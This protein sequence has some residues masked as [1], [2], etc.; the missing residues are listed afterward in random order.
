MDFIKNRK[1]LKRLSSLFII[2]LFLIFV[3]VILG[4]LVSNNVQVIDP[5]GNVKFITKDFHPS[6]SSKTQQLYSTPSFKKIIGKSNFKDN[7]IVIKDGKACFK[8]GID[9]PNES[10]RASHDVNNETENI[11]DIQACQCR[12]E[13]HGKACSEPE[14]IW[15]AFMVSRQP[16]NA[17]LTRHPHNIFYIINGVTSI[18]METLE[19]QILELLG[20]V[21]LFVLCD[22]VQT[23]DA[24]LLMQHQMNKDF[25]SRHKDYVLLLKDDTCSGS[26]IYRRMKRIIGSQMRPLDVLINGHSDEILNRKAVNYL[27]WHNNW[28]QPIRFRLRWNVYGF[29]FQHP[30]NTIIGSVACQLN[31]LEQFHKSD[32][33]KI[34]ANHYNPTVVT[35]GDLNHLGGWFCEYC[36][37]PID[38]IKKFH[39]DSKLLSN[40]PSDP[41]KETYHRKPVVNIEYI[42]NLI[43]Y[44]FY[45]DGKLELHKLR[46]YQDTKYFTPET[47]AKNR[48]KFDNIVTNF[49]TSWDDNL[50]Y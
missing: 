8:E 14:M 50:D 32:P 35:V 34:I 17:S 21:N 28:H 48:W 12:S 29:F 1:I 9:L 37:Q 16:M 42:Q 38:I 23:E 25:L 19:I 4:T 36:H 5:G 46:H 11:S 6:H 33:D 24:S 45:I 2:Q 30:D 18:N 31:F 26:N 44:G 15:R 47:V 49:Y 40:K 43:Q 41:L 22:L 27:K 13:W 20:I 3:F 7:F 10:K 39:L